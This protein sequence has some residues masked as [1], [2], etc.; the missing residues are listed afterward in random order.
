M[1]FCLLPR[2]RFFKSVIVILKTGAVGT[3][4]ET[5]C[6]FSNMPTQRKFKGCPSPRSWVYVWSSEIGPRVISSSEGKLE[7]E[8]LLLSGRK[9]SRH[10]KNPAVKDAFLHEKKNGT[11]KRDCA[12][13]LLETAPVLSLNHPR[14]PE[15]ER[16]APSCTIPSKRPAGRWCGAESVSEK[17]LNWCLRGFRRLS[18]NAHATREWER[19]AD[20]FPDWEIHRPLARLLLS[21]IHFGYMNRIW[22][23]SSF[24][25]PGER[26]IFSPRAQRVSS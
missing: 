3:F 22:Y 14:D 26:K 8:I 13:P 12:A 11:R 6:P 24:R 17:K 5:W 18:E 23:G 2:P 1:A 7:K 16:D 9:G 25:R 20:R 4:T 10:L 21:T 15:Y 19:W